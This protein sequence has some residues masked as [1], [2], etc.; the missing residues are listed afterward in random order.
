M[1]A[2]R[3]TPATSATTVDGGAEGVDDAASPP[4]EAVIKTTTEPTSSGQGE[5]LMAPR[6]CA[7]EAHVT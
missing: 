7:Y 6:C 3:A 4:H 1:Q 2:V 5:S